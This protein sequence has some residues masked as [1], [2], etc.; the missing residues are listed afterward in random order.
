MKTGYTFVAGSLVKVTEPFLVTVTITLV[1][2]HR[3]AMSTVVLHVAAFSAEEAVSGCVRCAACL[4]CSI[5]LLLVPHD[6]PFVVF[7]GSCCRFVDVPA[8]SFSFILDD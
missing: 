7:L 8:S 4:L 1:T 3:A 2:L 6:S 5:V